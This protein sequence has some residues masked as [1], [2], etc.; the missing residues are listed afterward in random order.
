MKLLHVITSMAPKSG[1][2]CQGIRN[3]APRVLE[4]DHEVE[5]V[6]LDDPN[7][8][9]LAGE[10]IFIHALGP[11][12]GSWGYHPGLRPWLQQ[13]LRRFD[14]VIL[15][16][17]W[18][19][20]GFV[21]SRLAVTPDMPPYYV[22]PHG[23]LDPW[24]QLARE[25]QF[26]A[27]RNWLYWKLIE[28]DV[29]QR[30]GALLFTCAEEMRLAG[31]TFRPY[32]PKREINVG[33]GVSDPPERGRPMRVAF[34]KKCPGLKGRPYLLFLGRIHPKKGV[35]SLIKAYAA[36]YGSKFESQ[37]SS[38]CLVIAGPGMDTVFGRHMFT[39]AA[40]T[41]PAGS[42]LWPGMLSGDDKWGS[43][44]GAEAF[45]LFSHQENFGIAVA[46]AL[47]C[48]IPVLISNQINIWRE[49]QEDQAG[50]VG[51]DTLASAEQTLRRWESHSPEDRLKMKHAAR[52]SYGSRFG[53]GHAARNLLAFL[54][55]STKP[56][57]AQKTVLDDGIKTLE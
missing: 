29:V 27:I 20:P 37:N 55:E 31:T 44:Y 25:R 32:Q 26:K 5:V 50:F 57:G 19:Y 2:P 34:E 6:C 17:L 16:G 56:P 3:L 7:S 33:Y 42:V 28:H 35:D 39:L 8:S 38:P 21:L 22:F 40:Q 24:F 45:A 11:G 14:A 52:F 18:Q 12:R 1:G 4:R 48:G 36:V 47:S 9:Y 23:M 10:S 53:I 15:N 41:C 30:A 43:L 49:I 54:E 13:N 46:E 51:D